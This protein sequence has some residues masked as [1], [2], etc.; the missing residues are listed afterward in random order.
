MTKWL[1]KVTIEE[2]KTKVKLRW[3]IYVILAI[4]WGAFAYW[5]G[6]PW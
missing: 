4:G 5:M 3:Y 6:M 1:C 2:G